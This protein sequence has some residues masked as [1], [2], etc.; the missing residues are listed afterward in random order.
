MDQKVLDDLLGRFVADLGATVSSANVV[1]GDRLGLYR[2][3][4]ESPA[5]SA[6]LA[7]RT[8][9]AERYVREWLRG[10]AAGGYVGYDAATDRYAMT[11]EQALAFADPAGLALPGAFQLAMACARD[12]DRITAAFRTGGGVGWGE[13][14]E[15]V[16][17]G[18]ERFFRPGYV[19]NIVGSWLPAL[20][21]VVGKLTAGAR[22][23]DV[24]CG[25]GTSSR[26][27]AEAFPAST[28]TGF[29]NH[30]ES[31][32]LASK[33]AG[34]LSD[35]V[36]FEVAAADA[37]GGTGY[38][39]VAN[40][41]SLHDMGDPV[42]AARHVRQALAPDGTWML[43]EP[44][45]ADD[46]AG[47]MNPVGRMYYGFS[48]FLCVPHAISEHA[49]DALGNQAGEPAMRRIAEE[50]GFTRFRR[51]AETPFNLVYELRP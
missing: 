29:D 27:I 5:T 39:L 47:N 19:A 28:V 35:R 9:T 8:G 11:E 25:L 51:A 48:T 12:L 34:D 23:A 17:T 7:A 46:V 45:A 18:T 42:A 1:V 10:Q 3:L 22:V 37:F 36:R 49:A 32:R 26:L 30:A 50:A 21:G 33:A 14:D 44:Y 16:Y 43:V 31:I 13:H 6:E 20:D 4:A 40:F 15:E 38:D 2:G 24:G 41:D